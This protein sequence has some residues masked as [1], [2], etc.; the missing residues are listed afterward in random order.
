MN[1]TF[2]SL[3]LLITIIA[4]IGTA[5]A[6]PFPLNNPSFESPA[7]SSTNTWYGGVDGW[8]TIG[9]PG[10]TWAAGFIEASPA[11]DGSQYAW[12]DADNWNLFQQTGTLAADTRYILKVDLYPLSTGTSRASLIIEETD[13]FAVVF[14][15]AHHKPT[16]DNAREDFALVANQWNTV[17]L[18]FNSKDFPA[19][20]GNNF[21][22]RLNGHRLAVDNFSLEVDSSIHDFYI[23]SSSGSNS[24]D[25]FSSA[26]PWENF[27][28]LEPYIPLLPGERIFLKRG[29]TF[30]QELNLRG[31]GTSGNL[32]ELSAYGTGDRP[33]I[34]RSDK[35][36]DK[37]VVWNNP[38]YVRISEL[39]CRTAK[40]G[41]HLRYEYDDSLGNSDV[42]I[43]NCHFEDMDDPTIDPS[44]H[45]FEIA[46]SSGIFMGGQAWNAAEFATFLTN[47]TIR[48]C[49]AVRA[50]HVFS[51]NYFY[52]GVYKSR[53]VNFTMEDCV[54]Y[55]CMFGLATMLYIDGGI[56]RRCRAL[57]GGGIDVWSGTSIGMMQGCKNLTVDDCEFAY[58][59]RAQSGDGVGFDFE[60]STDNCTF[61]NNI[62]HNND[63]S[64]LLI[65]ST[66]G[67][68]TN[69]TI[70]D[71]V[72]FNNC[73]DP[74]NDEI[75]SEVQGTTGSPTGTISNNVFYRGTSEIDIPVNFF[76][77]GS[78]WAGFTR[79]GNITGDY[80]SLNEERWWNFETNSDLEGWNG[81]N[82]WTN[83]TVTNSHL[84]GLSTGVD[85]YAL[86]PSTWINSTQYRYAWINM[87]ASAG[88]NA[89]IFYTTATDSV[90]DGTKSSLFSI[91]ADGE[92]HDY[93]ID[94][95]G[96]DSTKGMINQVRLDPTDADAADF[97]IQH[98]RFTD[99]LDPSQ[100]P[101][102][103]ESQSTTQAIIYATASQDG[104][105]TESGNDT[106]VGGS[107]SSGSTS[108]R[109]GDDSSNGAYRAILSFDTSSLPD[110]AIITRA[111][112]GI[113]RVGSGGSIPIGVADPWIG[114]QKVDIGVPYFGSSA[115][116]ESQDWEAPAS[117]EDIAQVCWPAYSNDMT[118]YSRLEDT[119][120]FL[121][122][123]TGTTQFRIHYPE[124]TNDNDDNGSD[125]VS[126]ATADHGTASLR[127][128]LI[129]RYRTSDANNILRTGFEAWEG[130]AADQSFPNSSWQQTL[131]D[132]SVWNAE[133]NSAADT[134]GVYQIDETGNET[135]GALIVR[136]QGASF[137]TEAVDQ[138][139]A[140]SF[141]ASKSSETADWVL[142]VE[143]RAGGSFWEQVGSVSS[144]SVGV[145]P[146]Y[147][148]IDVPIYDPRNSVELRWVL[149]S[150]TSGNCSIDDITLDA[151]SDSSLVWKFDVDGQSEGWSHQN[152]L[153]PLSVSSGVLTATITG[154]D[155]YMH[156]PSFS[157]DASNYNKVRVVLQNNTSDLLA[158]IL[159]TTSL[160][161]WSVNRSTTFNIVPN[162]S[163]LREYIID[164]SGEPEWTGTITQLRI[165]PVTSETTGTVDFD[166]IG[167]FRSDEPQ[168]VLA[169]VLPNPIEEPVEELMLSFSTAM[170]NVDISDLSLTKDGSPVDLSSSYLYQHGEGER[171]TLKNID[172]SS[173]GIGEYHLTLNGNDIQTRLHTQGVPYGGKQIWSLVA[174][175]GVPAAIEKLAPNRDGNG[176]GIWDD[177]QP[178]VAS[179][180][181]SKGLGKYITI[182]TSA[183][184]LQ[185][186]SATEQMNGFPEDPSQFPTGLVA[187]EV[188]SLTPGS[189]V[190]IDLHFQDPLP[191]GTAHHYFKYGKVTSG[192]SDLLYRFMKNPDPTGALFLTP[193]HVRLTF[194]D[195]A[196]G[197]D[198][199]AVNGV[200]VDPGG[201]GPAADP[202]LISLAYFKAT[203]LVE[204]STVE[205]EWAT[206]EEVNNAGFFIREATELKQ[207]VYTAG[208]RLQANLI[209]AEGSPSTYT[210]EDLR[211]LQPDEDRYYY[212]ED[213]DF[214]GVSTLRGPYQ[215]DRTDKSNNTEIEDW[216]LY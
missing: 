99:S 88:S 206:S 132:G 82:Q 100:F 122:N 15:E 106:G 27:D 34:V 188:T 116:L 145:R 89:Q 152:S 62:I 46:Y 81:F 94:L 5:T 118:V 8:S 63:G 102:I 141:F 138:P 73:R 19:Y 149:T 97:S 117:A 113:S 200:I 209:P 168:P 178:D 78:N 183:G 123:K 169:A 110:D 108:L 17:T 216:L 130:W 7:L 173:S 26:S 181:D 12:G 140:L 196:L 28:N 55:N 167:V 36:Y 96:M 45:N 202:L 80:S 121:I 190:D 193:N 35:L 16:W 182:G 172:L 129:I 50:G 205:I 207:G 103:D 189:A 133:T 68:H 101:S 30:T 39:D 174:G 161:G 72:L 111:A 93:F 57:G 128:H 194:I 53:L 61:T 179:L 109:I 21:R 135:P 58:L 52:P 186:V 144:A 33:K 92:Y 192:G 42:T 69:L 9:F 38:S 208:P 164:L 11:S 127:P 131:S 44:L 158:E 191:A 60:G 22:I 210:W 107:T 48:N 32:I 125:Y 67:D 213:I 204:G 47:L 18:S 147:T 3:I 43:E 41:I 59:D 176:D 31:K 177:L 120:L 156:S 159:W 10:T 136:S 126:Y 134:F 203:A 75:S 83:N 166:L 37:C 184:L 86:S 162:D 146:D 114:F 157:L 74:W 198:D 84:W 71:N 137:R 119:E 201:V 199:F 49:V 25:G 65:L 175:D 6:A 24:N 23:S 91:N 195:G 153:D 40:L 148:E 165:D 2:L 66:G 197:D 76:S 211:Y 14:A 13:S 215:V 170:E 1:H 151:S 154:N 150:R 143:K 171:Y 187:Y 163:I 180:P 54:A 155:P 87:K 79:T 105:V 139:G 124:P 51:T 98:I 142:S 112:F 20:V 212:L 29:D 90:W 95:G 56:I 115:A 85:P 185:N 104:Y 160:G 77:P 70:T 64:G 4:G 214:E